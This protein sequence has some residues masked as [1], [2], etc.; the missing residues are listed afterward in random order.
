MADEPKIFIDE[1]WKAQVQREKEEAQKK[2]GSE[3]P[4]GD[5]GDAG[6]DGA[7]AGEPSFAGLLQSL[8][9]QCAYALGLIAQRDAKQVM[10][11]IV[12]AKYCIDTLMMLRT[13]TKGNLTPEEE[14]LLANMI[15]ELQQFYVVRAQQVQEAEL[16]KA[17]ID[18]GN[19]GGKK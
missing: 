9:A 5:A 1:D 14:G 3:A 10:V 8:A 19:L 11:D 16:K 6:S 12:E 2:A 18:L 17:G 7:P 13:K 15:A 4:E